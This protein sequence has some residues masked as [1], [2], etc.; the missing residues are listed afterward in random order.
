MINR[1]GFTLIELLAVI[2]ILAIIALIATPVILNIINSA[3]ANAK[4][5]SAELVYTGVQY[6]YVSAMYGG[7][8]GTY[9][10]NPSLE[11]IKKYL[12][13]DN[14]DKE[15]KV[16]FDKEDAPEMLK[17]ETNDG[18]YCEVTIENGLQVS[19]YSST[20]KENA[21]HYFTKY[22]QTDSEVADVNPV[23][24]ATD[25]WHTIQKAVK[26]GNYPYK[27]G[28]T[29]TVELTDFGTFTLRVANTSTP[30]DCKKEGFS[31]TACGFVVEFQ[32][33]IT[34]HVMN[35]IDTNKGGWRDSDMRKYINDTIYK[36]LPTDLQNV[37]IGTFVV[38]GYGS[39]DSSNFETTDKLYLLAT[40]EIWLDGI[41]DDTARDKT[42][43][44][45][46]YA[47]KGVT[48]SNY[49]E[50][51]KPNYWWLRSSNSGDNRYFSR[52]GAVGDWDYDYSDATLGRGVSPAFRIG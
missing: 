50:A 4:Q 46:Y 5:R 3:R 29:K 24:F 9:V 11:D 41:S 23:S 52:V 48:K 26:S 28:D 6:A 18:A 44:L 31:Q 22:V 25:S 37:I 45:D 30:D 47:Q 14:V 27:V 33:I 51:I 39:E 7:I 43:Q 2:V 36:A 34:I 16:T 32:D 42:R 35:E 20:E 17:I 19:C 13:V 12:N 21:K 49:S 15:N 8:E 10:A 38:S 40:A 1:K